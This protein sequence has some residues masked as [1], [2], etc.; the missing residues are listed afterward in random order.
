MSDI[1][2]SSEEAA[3]ALPGLE[4]LRQSFQNIQLQIGGL[5]SAFGNLGPQVV[6]FSALSSGIYAMKLAVDAL[7]SSYTLLLDKLANSGSLRDA[8]GSNR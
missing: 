8:R 1:Q 6:A 7:C 5:A 2:I 3:Q 4:A